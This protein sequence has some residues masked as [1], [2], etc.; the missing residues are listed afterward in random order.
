MTKCLRYVLPIL[1]LA[2]G[3]AG[4]YPVDVTTEMHGLR[5]DA[6]ESQLALGM[7][8]DLVNHEPMA[9][10]CDV[11]FRN[12]PERRRRRATIEAAARRTVTFT[13]TRQVVRVRVSVEC[14]PAHQGDDPDDDPEIDPDIDQII[15][16]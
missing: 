2:W 9:V 13:P 6:N 16:E 4:A 15:E 8:I 11:H 14:W 7:L 12:G 10:R 3:G 5:I 1:M